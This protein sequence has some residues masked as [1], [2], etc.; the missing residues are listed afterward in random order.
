M[1]E[2]V[3]YA[4]VQGQAQEIFNIAM[5]HYIVVIFSSEE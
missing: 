3:P 4:T 1:Y 2:Y 5:T